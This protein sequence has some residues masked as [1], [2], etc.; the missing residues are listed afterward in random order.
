M[1]TGL[2]ELPE[3]FRPGLGDGI[4]QGI[5]APDISAQRMLH[6]DAI[7]KVDTVALAGSAAVSVI[8]P[9]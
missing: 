5:P 3:I 9:L 6:S 1:D 2:T 7:A 8:L 4:E